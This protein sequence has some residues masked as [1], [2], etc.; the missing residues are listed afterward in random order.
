MKNLYHIA[1]IFMV[2]VISNG[3]FRSPNKLTSD[4]YTIKGV[5]D[6]T[7]RQYADTNVTALYNIV[8]P[9]GIYE[10]VTF[11]IEGLPPGVTASPATVTDTTSF[12]VRVN[13][14]IFLEAPASFPV[15]A[16]LFSASFGKKYLKF[17]IIVTAAS[18]FSYTVNGLHDLNVQRYADTT[19][20][21]PLTTSYVAGIN[22]SVTIAADG[23]PSGV[24]VSP[25]TISGLP[26]FTDSFA[27]HI[28]ANAAGSFPVTIH[29]IS[30]KG[31][32]S[33]TF[34][35]NVSSSGNCAQPIAGGY[36]GSTVCASY[37]G[38]GTGISPCEV[39]TIGNNKALIHIPFGNVVADINC[40]SGTFN[41]EPYTGVGINIP[42]GTGTMNATTIV[43]N[44][45]LTGGINSTCTTTLTR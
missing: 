9:A 39:Y 25:G 6:I 24:T 28:T 21:L 18:P 22:E 32:K 40:S 4:T 8:V 23:L 2:A 11:N 14:H 34:N 15:T 44:Y 29:T 37:S 16:T 31:A 1:L 20:Y 30:S 5:S 38:A 26:T 7:V 17:N 10:P 36:S 3:C 43:V 12:S 13:F 33:A 41:I 42:S 27:F 35:I 45:A 19:V